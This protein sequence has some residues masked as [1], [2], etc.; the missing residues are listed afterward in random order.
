MSQ[1]TIDIPDLGPVIL[2]KRRGAKNLRLTIL[3]DGRVR[4][5]MPTWVPY[6]AGISFAKARAKW[7][8]KHISSVPDILLKDGQRIG[9]SYRLNFK[10]GLS[11][12][13]SRL[14]INSITITSALLPTHAEVQ[15]KAKAAAER[16]LKKEAGILL[17]NRLRQIARDNDF[18]YRR[19]SVKRLTSRWGSC[20]S[21][22][23]ITLNF[24]LVQLP[25]HL[26]DY[27]IV[28]ELAHTIQHNHSQAF[29][30]QVENVLPNYK[31]LKKQIKAYRPMILTD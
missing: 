11:G 31:D 28:H 7:I 17:E 18:T 8:Q 14:G 10:L 3:P 29:W 16:A 20:S 12:T 27:V 24:F 26:I 4:V 23:D 13:Q 22:G 30:K 9:K 19:F 1:K 15:T 6:S 21:K 2:A 25:W 5:S